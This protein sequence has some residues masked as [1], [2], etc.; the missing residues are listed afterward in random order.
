MEAWYAVIRAVRSYQLQARLRLLTWQELAVVLP[1]ALR[2][3]LNQKYG[4]ANS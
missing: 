1:P 3:F 2:E 4:I